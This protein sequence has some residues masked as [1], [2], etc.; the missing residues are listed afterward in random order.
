MKIAIDAMGGDF[1]P[2]VCVEGSLTALQKHKDIEIVLVGRKNELISLLDKTANEKKPYDKSRLSIFHCEE[3]ITGEDKPT[4]AVRA[5]KDS[6]MVKTVEL[7]KLGKVDACISAGNTGAY[8]ACGIFILGRIKG[9]SRPALIGTLPGLD[10]STMLLD[11]GANS[12]CKADNLVDFAV[13]AHVYAGA[14]AGI[15]HPTVALLNIGTEEGKGNELMRKSYEALKECDLIRFVGNLESRDLLRNDVDIVVT[16]GFTGNM[17]LKMMEGMA[18]GIFSLLKDTIGK[19]PKT[20]IGGLLLKKELK[21]MAKR[22]DHDSVGGVPL[23]GMDGV[24]MK[25]HGNSS[26]HAIASAIDQTILFLQSDALNRI[27]AYAEAKVE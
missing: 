24:M 5:K 12:D 9:I 3:V 13:M 26:A 6:S 19:S 21:N 20:K 18:S 7:L 22:M 15:E 14:I 8:L 25:C 16:D 23:L 11:I 27:R 4:Q 17:I 2:A 1:A 10:T